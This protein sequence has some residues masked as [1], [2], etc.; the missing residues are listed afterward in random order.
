MNG[1]TFIDINYDSQW[2]NNSLAGVQSFSWLFEWGLYLFILVTLATMIWIFFD[3]TNKHKDRQ[4]LVP[5]ILSLVGVFAIIPSFIFRF[6]GN[7]NGATHFVRLMAEPG[8]PFY[9]GPIYYNVRWLVMGFGPIVAIFALFGMTMSI[10]AMVIYASTLHRSRPSTEFVQAF[11]GRIAN[12]ENRVSES[13]RGSAEP[14]PAH[15]AVSIANGSQVGG[16][17]RSHGAATVVDRAPQAATI[18]DAPRSDASITIRSG[19]DCGRV[20][21]LPARDVTVGRNDSCNVVVDDGKVS[22]VHLRLLYNAGVWSALDSG[23][24]NGTFVNGNRLLG[25]QPLFD[26]DQIS[27]GDTALAFNCR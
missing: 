20:F 16:S 18:I 1:K 19:R 5:R 24:A 22:R 26:G 3:S 2:L 21:N 23:S 12:L 11:N 25:K 7:A 9:P 13:Q 14:G 27:M 8:A 6:T 15:G 10:V 17:M 4:A